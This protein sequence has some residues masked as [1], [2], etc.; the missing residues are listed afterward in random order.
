MADTQQI[1]KLFKELKIGIGEVSNISGVSQRQLRYWE[2]KGY[3]K[4]IDSS[5]GVRVYNFETICTVFFIKGKLDEG[6][7]LSAAYEKSKSAYT[8][9]KI[10]RKFFHNLVN[11]VEITDEKAAYGKILLGDNLHID[12][13]D[14]Q[15]VGIVDDDGN[16]FEIKK[17]K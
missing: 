14:Y 11:G 6:Y 7:T 16:H 8:K 2:Q 5:S 3:I 10:I 9:S 12:N 1:A 13:E 15:V 17:K 4:P